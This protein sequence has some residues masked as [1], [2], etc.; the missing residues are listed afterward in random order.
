MKT[1]FAALVLAI[2]FAGVASATTTPKPIKTPVKGIVK[3][4]EKPVQFKKIF[5]SS[6]TTQ[7]KTDK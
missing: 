3:A 7:N 6:T 5:G 2:G 1:T 4:D